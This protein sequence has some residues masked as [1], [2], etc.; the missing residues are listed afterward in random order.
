MLSIDTI[1]CDVPDSRRNVP[2]TVY[3]YTSLCKCS[4]ASRPVTVRVSGPLPS[5][6][7]VMQPRPVAL[8]AQA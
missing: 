8:Q 4:S 7:A 5:S 2:C 6:G 1:S 3:F